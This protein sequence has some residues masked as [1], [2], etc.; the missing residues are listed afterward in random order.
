MMGVLRSIVL[1]ASIVFNYDNHYI[2]VQQDTMTPGTTFDSYVQQTSVKRAG[3]D[4][5]SVSM[6]GNHND[7]HKHSF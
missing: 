5:C 1:R 4:S 2:R 3:A 6:W 7:H